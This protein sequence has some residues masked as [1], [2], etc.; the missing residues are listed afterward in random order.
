M[1]AEKHFSKIDI[2]EQ[3][4][5]VGGVWN[6]TA[7]V[8]GRSWDGGGFKVPQTEAHVRLERPTWRKR[9]KRKSG[10]EELNGN[11]EVLT[12]QAASSIT[13]SC[14]TSSAR[15]SSSSQTSQIIHRNGRTPT[16]PSVDLNLG[17]QFNIRTEPVFPSPMYEELETNIPRTLMRFS[18]LPFPSDCQLF[19][20]HEAVKTY[21]DEYGKE[22]LPLVK[23]ETQVQEVKLL[24]A[25]KDSSTRDTSS[26]SETIK[27]RWS[28]QAEELRTGRIYEEKYDAV[29]LA[30][31][32]YSVP[33]VPY[34]EGAKEWNDAF[35]GTL[36]HSKT[37][38]TAEEYRD[39]VRSILNLG[40]IRQKHYL[41]S[42]VMVTE[43][44]S[45]RQLRVW[46]RHRPPDFQS[47]YETAHR[48]ATQTF[49]HGVK[50]FAPDTRSTTNPEL[51]P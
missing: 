18:D 51:P 49:R 15:S 13:S 47:L 46:S 20:R 14:S 39:K 9:K 29:I 3:S 32:H 7:D 5:Q 17:N 44:H 23:F 21:I 1:I 6:Y 33:F 36:S 45:N 31:G 42:R 34:I 30:N 37:F 24:E 16:L 41:Y 12:D 35:P 2:F 27:E 50:Y 10:S 8:T 22:L 28:L 40:F 25:T 48:I 4:S 26:D 19:P 11:G 38:R 43:S